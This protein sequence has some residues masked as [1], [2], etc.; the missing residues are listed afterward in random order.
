[1]VE[2]GSGGGGGGCWITIQRYMGQLMCYQHT[3]SLLG[4][5][6][7]KLTAENRKHTDILGAIRMNL[8]TG[9]KN[10]QI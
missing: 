7:M 1:M 5:I 9:N 10:I 3:R 4:A 6:R 2:G 8:S